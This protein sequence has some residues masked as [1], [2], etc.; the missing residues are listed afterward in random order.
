MG[1]KNLRLLPGLPTMLVVRL[2]VAPV[3]C[4]GI[5][6]L[7]GVTGLAMQVFVVESALPW[8]V[9]YRCCLEPSGPMSSTPPREPV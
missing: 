2:G 8:S 3:I 1:L 7:F 4:W 6:H 9:R 5:C